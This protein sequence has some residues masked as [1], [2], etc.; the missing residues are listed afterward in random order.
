[1]RRIALQLALVGILLF[2]IIGCSFGGREQA[3]SPQASLPSTKVEHKLTVAAASDLSLAFKEIGQAFEKKTNS[4]IEFTFSSTGTLAQQI[5]N[6]A[7]FDIFA[8]ADISFVNDLKAKG[9]I[10]ADTQQLYAQGRIGLATTMKSTLQVKEL[11][12]FLDPQ[13]KKIAIA[14]PDHAPYGLAAKQALQKA[15]LWDQL[16]DKLVFGKNISETLTFITT[17]NAEAGIIA[18]SIVKEDETRFRLIDTS[19]YEPLNQSIAVIKDTR[20][21]E[22]ARQFVAYVN[23]PESRKIMQKYGFAPPPES[24]NE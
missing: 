3:P 14:N 23:E 18:Q 10:I 11:K 21:E 5:E 16:Q 1:M 7:P 22:L 19:L 4:K 20:E 9:K 24:K 17:G 13:I 15:G 8:A 12:D 2:T 6:G